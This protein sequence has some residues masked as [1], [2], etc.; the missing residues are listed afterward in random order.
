MPTPFRFS[1]AT[2][3]LIELALH[4]DLSLGDVTADA[5][6]ADDATIGA[7]FL[8][9]E[10]LVVAGIPIVREVMRQVDPEATFA[11]SVRD[12]AAITPG[13]FGTVHGRVRSL[14]RAE[15]VMLN[16]LRHMSGV[17]TITKRYVAALGP[18]GPK[19]VDTR[20]TTPGFREL[21]KYA[22]RLGGGHNHRYNL[23]SG[24]MI[25]DNHIAAAG[26]IA[27]AVAKVRAYAPFLTRI[28]VE[29]TTLDELRAALEAG[30]DAVLLDNMSTE[31]M[32]EACAI[33]AGRAIVEASGNI[34]ESRLAELRDVG[35]DIVSSGAITHSAP[36]VDIS[37]D[38][39][40]DH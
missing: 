30:A 12:G 15:R 2:R 20:K 27:D 17:A 4:E 25:K 38:F 9:K 26:S 8:A 14:L 29:V 36:N 21:E 23:G 35:L 28:E 11:W 3:D 22:V 13:Q 24:A 33:V 40:A 37:L 16:F 1:S 5:I 10:P 31:T 34:T 39:F 18:N 6:F 7:A 19:L 32:R